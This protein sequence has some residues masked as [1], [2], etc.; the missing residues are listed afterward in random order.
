MVQ[1]GTSFRWNKI[2][3]QAA[4]WL[5]DGKLT[6]EEIARNLA[7]GRETISR[8]KRQPEFQAQIKQFT[9]DAAAE[10]FKESIR[11][12]E[13]RIT[14]FEELITK[15]DQIIDERAEDLKDAPGGKSGLLV[16]QV[17]SIGSGDRSK[18][19]EE[20]AID[21]GLLKE[22]REYCKQIAIELGEWAERRE[23]SGPNGSPIV[24]P[25]LKIVIGGEEVDA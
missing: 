22:Y 19:V 3:K 7:I 13:R 11:N 5:A 14:R 23:H 18:E 25:S 1:N 10:L 15:L 16:R 8:W 4:Q 24:P 20:Y 9:D 17:K 2:R 12:K 6:D 21:V